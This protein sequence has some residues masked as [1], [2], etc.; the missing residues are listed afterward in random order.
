MKV[1]KADFE[2]EFRLAKRIEQARVCGPVECSS[3]AAELKTGLAKT[4][5]SDPVAAEL[6]PAGRDAAPIS[7]ATAP[8][9]LTSI[10]EWLDN[11]ASGRRRRRRRADPD[12][13]KGFAIV[14]AALD[15]LEPR[16]TKFEM[17]ARPRVTSTP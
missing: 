2:A 9:T 5:G 1:S 11:L 13:V 14:S 8:T 3:S 12:N 10:S 17:L 6:A 4:Q 7:G 16:W 15:Q